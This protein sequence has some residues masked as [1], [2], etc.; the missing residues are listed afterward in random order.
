MS[1]L[2]SE[3]L[4]RYRDEFRAN[5]AKADQLGPLSA[6]Q[7]NWRPGQ[8]RWSVAECLVHL[9]IS[10]TVFSK[11]ITQAVAS[12]RARGLVGQGP[13]DSG[14]ISRWF[15]RMMEPPIKKRYKAPARFLPSTDTSYQVGSVLDD[16][17]AAGARWDECLE[18]ANG[19]DLA[20]V[21]VPS[22]VVPLIRFRLGGLFAGQAAHER[23][24]L[25]QAEQVTLAPGFPAE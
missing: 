9:N 2:L 11:Q 4:A 22:P 18:S 1:E 16:F 23:R 21:K 13:F 7:F 15:L 6:A 25:W 5:R 12:G 20:R 19:L 17:R 24:H 3:E 8:G 14:M 10:A